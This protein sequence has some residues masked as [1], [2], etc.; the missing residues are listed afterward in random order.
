MMLFV[1]VGGQTNE[2]FGNNDKCSLA[3]GYLLAYT[4]RV[5]FVQYQFFHNAMVY[6]KTVA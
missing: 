4:I 6:L 5:Q 2:V 1:Y 3:C